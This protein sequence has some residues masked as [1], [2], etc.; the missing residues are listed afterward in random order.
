VQSW[1]LAA[2]A[3][4]WPLVTGDPVADGGPEVTEATGGPAG[5]GG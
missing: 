4:L 1:S 5:G 3:T 2:A